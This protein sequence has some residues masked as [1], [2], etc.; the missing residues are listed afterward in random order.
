MVSRGG[1]GGGMEVNPVRCW[2]ERGRWV[3]QQRGQGKG[4]T[5]DPQWMEKGRDAR[6]GEEAS[7]LQTCWC[8][9]CASQLITSLGGRRVL[10]SPEALDSGQWHAREKGGAE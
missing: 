10:T 2:E 1:G 8:H 7:A 3:A 6:F 4:G 5:R 9:T